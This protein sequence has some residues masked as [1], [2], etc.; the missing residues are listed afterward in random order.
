MDAR[1]VT[2]I[3]GQEIRE[4]RRNRWFVLF[5]VIFAGL[6]IGLSLLGMSGLGNIGIAGF[7]RTAASLLNLVIV[8]VSLMAILVGAT[9]VVGDRQQGT[10]HTLLAQPITLEELLLGKFLGLAFALLATVMA[11]FGLS[12]LV[13]TYYGG[14]SQAGAYCMLVAF[15]CL[16]AL[17]FLS[18]GFLVSTVLRKIPTALGVGLFL[19]LACVLLSDLGL[20][21][22]AVVLDLSPRT[23]LWLSLVN[24]AQVYKL[25]VLD[26]IQG[27]L[28]SLGPAGS[29]AADVFGDRLRPVLIGVLSAW[30]LVPLGITMLLF[31]KRGMS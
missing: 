11:G 14:G 22:T 27:N 19:W 1:A 18:V 28:E 15:T 12:A 7:G 6:A 9:G 3:M 26:S 31:R 16:F 25:L 29:Y 13:I 24:P 2:L 10:L 21:G 5:A 20:M 4:A 17:A 8:I 30:T 23:L